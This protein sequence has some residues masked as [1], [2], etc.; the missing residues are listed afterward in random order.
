MRS[1]IEQ[2]WKEFNRQLLAFI[3]NKVIDK[4]SAEDILQDVFI[5]VY[6]NLNTLEDKEKL[7]SW[8]YSITRNAIY[9]FYRKKSIDFSDVE[10]DELALKTTFKNE[11]LDRCIDILIK[12]LPENY[13]RVLDASELQ[14]QKQQEISEQQGLS[15]PAVKSRIKRGRSQLKDKLQACC[16]FEFKEDGGV[17][18]FCRNNCGCGG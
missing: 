3:L 17:E 11:H 2:I 1:M 8:L 14:G 16:D 6:Q 9:D 4:S 15:L 5:K 10:L 18:S 13:S 7:R 12:D